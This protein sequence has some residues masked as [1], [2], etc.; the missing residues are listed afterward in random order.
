VTVG[1]PEFPT[2]LDSLV[3]VV[4]KVLPAVVW[5]LDLAAIQWDHA[6]RLFVC[7][8]IEIV[9]E[10]LLRL[11]V[12][13]A[14]NMSHVALDEVRLANVRKKKMVGH[15]HDATRLW[16]SSYWSARFLTYLL[17]QVCT[18]STSFMIFNGRKITLLQRSR[19]NFL[20]GGVQHSHRRQEMVVAALFGCLEPWLLCHPWACC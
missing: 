12:T 7:G 3:V 11:E 2:V 14:P 16:V 19:R 1:H 9:E 10:R 4:L 6:L 20:P 17:E 8:L 13:L 5:N 18:P 15:D